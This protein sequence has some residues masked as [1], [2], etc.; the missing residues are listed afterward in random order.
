METDGLGR[1]AQEAE[2]AVYF[3]CLEAMQN[4]A[5]YA[6]ASSVRVKLR[7]EDGELTFEVSD[8]GKGFDPER[9]PT[10]AGLENMA[11]R[12]AALG[13]SLAIRSQPGRGTTVSGRLPVRAVEPAM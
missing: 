6:E 13:G 1:Y 5:K 3:C 4:V 7:I 8:D 9:T 10:G 2:A 12:L 11:D